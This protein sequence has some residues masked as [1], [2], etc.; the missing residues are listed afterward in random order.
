MATACCGER[1]AGKKW[2][3]FYTGSIILQYCVVQINILYIWLHIADFMAVVAQV[4]SVGLLCVIQFWWL[5]T[6][7]YFFCRWQGKKKLFRSRP[8]INSFIFMFDKTTWFYHSTCAL[9]L[10]LLICFNSWYFKTYVYPDCKSVR[11]I[12]V[13]SFK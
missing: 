3:L 6:G 11:S 2:N 5:S 7:T 10:I 8:F 4:S 9:G 1:Y 12:I 13:H